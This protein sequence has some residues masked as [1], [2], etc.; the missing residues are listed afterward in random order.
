MIRWLELWPELTKQDFLRVDGTTRKFLVGK[1]KQ[2][3]HCMAIQRLA[4]V[5]IT[6]Y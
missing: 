4:S 1:I 2:A 6:L 5:T 3:H